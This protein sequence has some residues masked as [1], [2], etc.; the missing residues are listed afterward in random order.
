MASFFRGPFQSSP[1]QQAI[2]KVT[3]ENQ[4]AE[5]WSLIMRICDHVVQSEER[6]SHCRIFIFCLFKIF[7]FNSVQ[8][9][10]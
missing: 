5:D 3:D 7:Q 1:F 9:K 4:P 8:K 6:Y 2:E 10:Q